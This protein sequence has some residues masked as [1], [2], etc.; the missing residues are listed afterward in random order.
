VAQEPPEPVEFPGPGQA[1]PSQTGFGQTG[2]GQTGFGQAEPSQDSE[3]QFTPIFQTPSEPL[4]DQISQPQPPIPSDTV[5]EEVME[6]EVEPLQ[7]EAAKSQPVPSI[8]SLEK[9][10][11][12]EKSI[13][14]KPLEEKPIEEK[15]APAPID[16]PDLKPMS[17]LESRKG[18]LKASQTQM[19][20]P[21]RLDQTQLPKPTKTS[22]VP[23][24][25]ESAKEQLTIQELEAT[26]EK[27]TFLS[28]MEIVYY[29]LLRAAFTQYLV[30]PKVVSRAAVKVV[31][32]NQDHL[33][34]AENV[35]TGTSISFVICDVKLNIRAIVEVVDES[36]GP[37]NNKDKA[38]DYILKKAGCVL[39]RFYSG[40]TPPD[41]VTL[42]RLLLD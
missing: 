10:Q 34:M 9:E 27:I 35:L 16:I 11:A 33:K 6:L 20:T 23:E 17:V 41:V 39:I 4:N 19:T 36:Q 7:S 30:F 26:Y 13:V 3:P 32:R 29:K 2:F 42:R 24:A 22:I 8:A 37:S 14:E 40:D 38:R 15:I 31:S 1:E 21:I 28:P 5:I 18:V 25:L 12:E